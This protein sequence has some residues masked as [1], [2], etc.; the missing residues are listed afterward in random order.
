M[1]FPY[2][3]LSSKIRSGDQYLT[4]K[5]IVMIYPSLNTIVDKLNASMFAKWGANVNGT[6]EIVELNNIANISDEKN[7][8]HNKI[9]LTV[10]KVEE[11]T[12]LK[13]AGHFSRT[14]ANQIEKHEPAIYLN[15][16]LLIAITKKDYREALQLLSDTITYFQSNRVFTGEI[17][18]AKTDA[19]TSFRITV[20]L[21]ETSFQEIF[22]MWSNLGSKV[23]PSIIYKIRLLKFFDASQVQ[24]APLI[25][26]VNL[27][28]QYDLS[29][30]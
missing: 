4:K 16:Y 17:H 10:L 15:L 21:H 7:D 14:S 3:R 20:E 25:E 29:D 24:P 6:S 26:K 28:E 19:R 1:L 23:F 13:N 27:H 22:D 30:Q 9:I 5:C 2:I 12:S 11:E 8:L 18:D